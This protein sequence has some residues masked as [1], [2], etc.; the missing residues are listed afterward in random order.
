[1]DCDVAC[2][3][4][5]SALHPFVCGAN[6]I[7]RLQTPV[8]GR[9][10]GP[11]PFEVLSTAPGRLLVELQILGV[12]ASDC[13]DECGGARTHPIAPR[14]HSEIAQLA[15]R[16]T[17]ERS[18]CAHGERTALG[19]SQATYVMSCSFARKA[20]SHVTAPA[21][22]DGGTITFKFHRA[23]HMHLERTF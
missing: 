21:S 17:R 9:L 10:L 12:S 22:C 14:Q 18:G 16:S 5:P 23:C 7:A 13:R 11:S 15:A 6:R 4:L 3:R 8:A 20:R 19:G 1:M 2:T